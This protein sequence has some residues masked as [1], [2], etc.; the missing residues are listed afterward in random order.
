MALFIES[1]IYTTYTKENSM[2]IVEIFIKN[3]KVYKIAGSSAYVFVHDN[4]VAETTTMIFKKKQEEYYDNNKS[5]RHT[6]PK[7]LFNEETEEE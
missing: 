3:D 5:I 2:G 1:H 4:D 6:K 7:I